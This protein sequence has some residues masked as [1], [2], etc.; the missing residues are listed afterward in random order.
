MLPE[1]FTGSLIGIFGALITQKIELIEEPFIKGWAFLFGW[2]VLTIGGTVLLGSIEICKRIIDESE[3]ESEWDG[4]DGKEFDCECCYC[5]GKNNSNEDLSE[6][7]HCE[8]YLC[9]DPSNNQNIS[10][11]DDISEQIYKFL[12]KEN[13]SNCDEKFSF[14]SDEELKCCK[15]LVAKS[16]VCESQNESDG[17][18]SLI[19]RFISDFN[20]ISSQLQN[21]N[22]ETLPQD[23]IKILTP[24]INVRMQE[25]KTPEQLQEIFNN[26]IKRFI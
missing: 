25:F 24:A 3:D 2:S 10:F 21:I 11:P 22:P 4:E 15:D 26:E 16:F 9:S 12:P 14:L 23:I 18:D 8:C 7:T 13:S 19:K 17:N 6:I 5:F 20:L 1:L